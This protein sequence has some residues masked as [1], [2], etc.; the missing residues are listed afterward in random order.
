M[1]P[2]L[3]RPSCSRSSCSCPGC[4]VGT[5]AG[6]CWR[7]GGC[8]SRALSSLPRAWRRLRWRCASWPQRRHRSNSGWLSCRIGLRRRR[9]A[10]GW[11]AG[12]GRLGSAA[13]A[14]RGAGR[15]T[16]HV[17]GTHGARAGQAS[18]AV[19]LYLH[20]AMP[21]H[22]RGADALLSRLGAHTAAAPRDADQVCVAHGGGRGESPL[23][24]LLHP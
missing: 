12:A 5:A 2:S 9:E 10:G 20:R 15:G 22:V 21:L 1:A 18:P 17:W 14:G 7:G 19:E 23:V 24:T 4:A 13:R 16:G 11:E 6:L 8:L 3:P